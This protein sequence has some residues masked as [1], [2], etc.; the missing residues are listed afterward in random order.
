M[1][2]GE[3]DNQTSSIVSICNKIIEE[4]EKFKNVINQFT[5][6]DTL[7]GKAYTSS[8]N[9]FKQVYIPLANGVIMA[10]EAIN[11]ANRKFPDA[12]R[13]E[14]DVNDVVEDLLTGQIQRLNHLIISLTALE[15]ITPPVRLMTQSM[16][17]LQIKLENKLEKLYSFNH[18]SLSFFDEAELLLNH[19]EAGVV[20]VSAGKGW[21]SSTKTFSPSSMNLDWSNAINNKW[22]KRIEKLEDEAIAY[23]ETLSTKLPHVTEA[24]MHKLFELTKDVQHVEVPEKLS[25]YLMG[26]GREIAENFMSELKCNAVST[27]LEASGTQVKYIAQ[28]IMYYSAKWG[29]EGPN[30]FVMVSTEA[31]KRT[32]QAV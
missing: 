19:V 14:V 18:E 31:A 1:F 7:Q 13:A 12:F 23:M 3:V 2:L 4:M 5:S 10:S 8:K 15:E 21:N 11:E 6:Q 26:E 9:Y 29:P 20:E 28:L 17:A 24:E 32:R 25:E 27:V 22:N 30:S 16:R